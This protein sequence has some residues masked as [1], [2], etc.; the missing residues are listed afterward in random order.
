M[1][2]AS[3]RCAPPGPPTI[4]LC[5]EHYGPDGAIV[6][7]WVLASH[8]VGAAVAAFLGGLA[9]DVFG[10]YDLVWYASGAL[11]A[12]AALMAMVIRRRGT[13]AAAAA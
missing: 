13:P 5:R 4:A 3:A 2:S 7:G 11:C 12:M 9:R 6:F 8:Q 1:S 10:S